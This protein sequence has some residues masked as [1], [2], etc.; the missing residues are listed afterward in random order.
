MAFFKDPST[1]VD[2]THQ[3][4]DKTSVHQ[5]VRIRQTERDLRTSVGSVGG[6]IFPASPKSIPLHG[7]NLGTVYHGVSHLRTH[8]KNHLDL[9]T[10]YF[11]ICFPFKSHQESHQVDD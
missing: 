4:W 9:V 1:D 7:P 8:R 2:F 3:N 5:I 11:V 10:Y 6:Y